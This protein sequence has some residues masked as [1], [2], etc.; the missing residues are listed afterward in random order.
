MISQRHRHWLMLLILLGASF[1]RLYRL[2]ELPPGLPY[3]EACSLVDALRFAQY[4]LLP[5]FVHPQP[6]EILYQIL[7]GIFMIF[8]GPIRLVMHVF[9]AYWGLIGVAFTYR[10]ARSLARGFP[11]REIVGLVSAG[12]MAG[13]LNHVVLSRTG[14]RGVFLPVFIAAG[15]YLLSEGWAKNSL[16]RLALAGLVFGAS[17]HAYTSGLFV[18][19]AVLP[20]VVHQLI[21]HPRAFRERL[22]GLGMLLG[23]M[24]LTIAPLALEEA[25]NPGPLYQRAIDMGTD[26]GVESASNMLNMLPSVP[27]LW[28][29]ATIGFYG[30]GDDDFQFNVDSAPLLNPVLAILAVLGLIATLCCPRR[31]SSAV[32]ISFFVLMLLPI[33]LSEDDV[34][35][36][37]IAGEF[38]VVAI[39][40][41][42]AAM[43]L[44]WVLTC[45]GKQIGRTVGALVLGA[46][47]VGSGIHAGTTY[48][49][50]F[51]DPARW[52]R[53]AWF[54]FVYVFLTEHVELAEIINQ[55][56]Q[57]IY[58]STE[59][60]NLPVT[61][62]V[63]AQYYPGVH[64]S[65][66]FEGPFPDG[67]VLAWPGQ[68]YTQHYAVLIPSGEG[69]PGGIYLLPALAPDAAELL[70]NRLVDEGEQL[71][72]SWGG[73][74]AHRLS[75]SGDANP[76]RELIP[77][78]LGLIAT[79]E[80]GMQLVGLDAPQTIQPGTEIAV[81]LY[82]HPIRHMNTEYCTAVSLVGADNMGLASSDNWIYRWSYD[83]TQWQP[84]ELIPDG[85]YLTLPPD[86]PPGMY[87]LVVSVYPLHGD[88]LTA[89]GVAGEPL[90][91]Y[92]RV[93]T[94]KVP[95]TEQVTLP[96]DIITTDATI[97]TVELLGY[98]VEREGESIPL[99]E[100]EP[101]DTLTLTFYWHA[102]SQLTSNYHL[103]IHL[104]ESANGEVLG[105]FDGPPLGESYP[106][107]IWG[108]DEFLAS[109]HTIV[110]PEGHA[111]LEIRVGMYEWPSLERLPVVQNGMPSDDNCVTLYPEISS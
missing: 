10:A 80:N 6:P 61:R 75:V 38:V 63:L 86:L 40:I 42:M 82:W 33:A 53:N 16:W 66:T 49:P 78:P 62:Y 110:W 101:G 9:S 37:R 85:H 22:P 99:T 41:G 58:L 100:A 24:A 72:S 69:S 57:P 65:S 76:F 107:L 43:A 36:M 92:F 98:T 111:H 74:I 23:V 14:F 106:T 32:L 56:D 87:Q 29:R 20:V 11:H 35:G 39:L 54:N 25:A 50:Y 103:F 28:W 102:T 60:L 2:H 64:A 31:L 104:Q 3:D 52:D 55:S 90:G 81:T 12:V 1:L 105:G 47:V 70:G 30:Y 34:Q 19:I 18:P 77:P 27:R 45:G 79:F 51:A 108:P 5:S 83:T 84:G 21:F 89:V 26:H 67:Q 91:D 71:S 59:E 15:W 4:G 93:G 44:M 7:Q 46:V 73:V 17:V 94:L 68:E 109:T 95:Q 8:V 97:G 13:L 96:E 88:P 48:F